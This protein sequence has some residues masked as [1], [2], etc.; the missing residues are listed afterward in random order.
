MTFVALLIQ[1]NVCYNW[2]YHR[3]YCV[4]KQERLVLQYTPRCRTYC[5]PVPCWIDRICTTLA[6]AP[7]FS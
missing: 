2:V 3:V 7:H 6:V 1:Q 4:F 5:S